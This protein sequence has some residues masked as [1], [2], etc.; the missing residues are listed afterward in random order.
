MEQRRPTAAVALGM[1]QLYGMH[2]NHKTTTGI[3]LRKWT[4]VVQIN[5]QMKKGENPTEIQ[6][7]V[8]Q[9]GN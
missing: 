9:K 5:I 7:P 4:N 3:Y 1:L 6:K 2:L 8:E